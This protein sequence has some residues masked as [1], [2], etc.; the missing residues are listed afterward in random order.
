[1]VASSAI[2]GQI[3]LFSGDLTLS[4]GTASA[5]FE[6][7]TSKQLPVLLSRDSIQPQFCFTASGIECRIISLVLHFGRGSQETIACANTCTKDLRFATQ[8]FAPV[9]KLLKTQ[10][11][12]SRH[13]LHHTDNQGPERGQTTLF[14]RRNS[15]AQQKNLP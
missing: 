6:P 9:A 11:M 2:S 7:G 10:N 15:M 1:M 13:A 8:K 4:P 3:G 5:G 12:C 14:W